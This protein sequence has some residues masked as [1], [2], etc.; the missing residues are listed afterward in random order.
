MCVYLW[1]HIQIH[2]NIHLYMEHTPHILTYLLLNLVTKTFVCEKLKTKNQAGIRKCE[3]NFILHI[4]SISNLWYLTNFEIS[5]GC[6]IIQVI[7]QTKPK[8]TM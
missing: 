6:K 7:K 8:R 4:L 2:T 3:V 1:K 5:Y